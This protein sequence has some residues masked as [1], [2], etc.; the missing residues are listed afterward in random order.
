LCTSIASDSFRSEPKEKQ[1]KKCSN[2]LNVRNV[3]SR[4][5]ICSHGKQRVTEVSK[6]C[7][8]H[9]DEIYYPPKKL[10]PPKSKYGFDLLAEI[11][12]YRFQEHRQ[13]KEI[14]AILK[15][16]NITVPQRTIENLTHRFLQYAV[17]V[18]LE[19]LPLL[20]KFM[21]RNGGYTLQIDGSTTR[22][23]P[24]L[25]L[26]KDGFSGIRLLSA[27]IPTES[28][29]HVQPILEMILHF[30]G[31]P[32]CAIRDGG[33]GIRNALQNTFP[34]IYIITCHY[35]FLSNVGERLLAKKY[36]SFQR[37]VHKTGILK[38]LRAFKKSILHKKASDERD[39]ALKLVEYVHDYKAD[40]HGLGFPF[41]VVTMD[42]YR[43]CEEIRP[44]VQKSIFKRASALQ[45]SP[46]LI[47]LKNALDL[48]QPP[49]AVRGRIHAEYLHLLDRWNWFE[50]IRKALRY[51]NGPIPLNNR[52]YLS[53]RELE[54]GRSE[55][56]TLQEEIKDFLKLK[57]N[58][59]DRN[60]KRLLR[61][62]SELLLE[63]RNE[64]FAPNVELDVNGRIEYRKLPR[65]NNAVEQDFRKIR[66]YWRRI[67]GNSDVEKNV[68][69]QG[70]GQAIVANFEIK[71][72]V[73]VV[74]RSLEN[75]ASRFA[76]VSLETL[77]RA[78][79]LFNFQR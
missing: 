49:P 21:K 52:G 70:V 53:D 51:R 16:R 59:K 50:R 32:I 58:T 79:T 67:M 77:E 30:F 36:R 78:N 73:S 6:H 55:L 44:I 42:F 15:K 10:T 17:A 63:R 39:E 72:Y 56:D 31:E 75:M 5:I 9:P 43:R 76:M 19:N 8:Q 60:I 41:S 4:T 26:V 27:S 20:A 65:T 23:S 33:D 38:K 11:G 34:D 69:K 71:E 29:D 12:Q 48:L 18:H 14:S 35:H 28:C 24:E 22:G 74:Y 13:I 46:N 3:R 2:Q 66:R 61:G 40:A 54:E 57:G 68:Q 37:R 7:T 1:C 25:L 62:V 64:L 47:R 45:G